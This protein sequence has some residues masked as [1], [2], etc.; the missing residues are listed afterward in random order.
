[1]VPEA[2]SHPYRRS[3]SRVC[4]KDIHKFLM[5][6][7]KLLVVKHV[8]DFTCDKRVGIFISTNFNSPGPNHQSCSSNCPNL[9]FA[10][11]AS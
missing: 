9:V 2:A 10:R 3:A 1:M 8:T 11:S 6:F 5:L 4:I 7:D